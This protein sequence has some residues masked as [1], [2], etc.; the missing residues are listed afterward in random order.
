MEGKTT[1]SEGVDVGYR[2]FDKQKIEPLFP[3]GYGLS[4][5]SFSGATQFGVLVGCG[6]SLDGVRFKARQRRVVVA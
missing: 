1:F 3:F 5:S 2:W 6:E 4:Y